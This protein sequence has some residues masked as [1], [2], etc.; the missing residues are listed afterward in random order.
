MMQS[1]RDSSQGHET[2]KQH[3]RG[4]KNQSHLSLEIIT[5]VHFRPD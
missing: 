4:R 1:E 2:E 5:E 3:L